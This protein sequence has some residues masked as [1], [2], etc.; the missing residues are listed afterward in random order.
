[1]SSIST[2]RWICKTCDQE[3][4][5]QTDLLLVSSEDLLLCPA[6]AKDA[7]V[8]LEEYFECSECGNGFDDEDDAD[9]CCNEESEEEEK[10]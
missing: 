2:E 4:Y 1:M 8:T 7:E 6:C 3:Y 5:K 10:K 9:S